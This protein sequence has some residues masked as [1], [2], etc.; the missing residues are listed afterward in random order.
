M[1]LA[2]ETERIYRHSSKSNYYVYNRA[3]DELIALSNK[4]KQIYPA[5][6][7]DG[8]KVAYVQG[9][10]IHVFDIASQ[11]TEQITTDG[12]WNKIINGM[13]DWVYEE[14]LKLTR[15]F[16]WSPDS[17]K[18]AYFKFDEED[19]KMF[20]MDYYGE[21][22]PEAYTFKYPKAGEENAEVTAHI[23]DLATKQ[24]VNMEMDTNKDVYYARMK[25]TPSGDK[26]MLLK[27]NRQQNHVELISGNTSSGKTSLLYAE[28]NP[29]Y[30]AESILDNLHFLKDESGF[31]WTSENDG[32][33]HL[34]YYNM[35][36]QLINQ[37]TTGDYDVTDIYGLDEA[38]NVVY[39]QS[40]ESSPLDRQVY[41]VNLNG[42]GKQ[43]LT[44][45]PGWHSATFTDSYD[46]FI[47][48]FSNTT[49]PTQITVRD[50][51]GKS[52]RSLEDNKE[53]GKQVDALKL[54]KK[55]FFELTAP[56]GHSLNGWMIKPVNFDSSKSYPMMMFV[57]GGPGSQTVRNRWGDSNF[58][59][60]Q[61]LAQKGY[62]VVSVDNRGT[63]ARG[64][65]FKKSTYLQLGKYET[66]D[67]IFAAKELAKRSFIDENRIGIWGWS[68]GGYMSSLALFKGNDIFDAAVAVAPVTHWGYYDT[69]YTE[70]FMRTPQE[71]RN[72]YDDNSPINFVDDL[73]GDYLLV[74]GMGD[75]NVHFQNTVDMISALN[76]AGKH[77]DL[78]IYPNKNHGIYGGNTRQHLFE[79]ITNFLDEK[80]MNRDVDAGNVSN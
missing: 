48:N 29:Y 53:L 26:L 33:H 5:F 27:L 68:Y 64:Q 36:G 65:E 21:L 52:V 75:D 70:R 57:Y 12:E 50:N 67:Q 39:Y 37:V 17:K 13:S 66:E 71:N 41:S 6:S 14:E 77:Y 22:Y 11:S 25:W 73:K 19:V 23:H 16:E 49:T 43:Q 80:L 40:A 30:V 15:A 34:Y 18:I 7:P 10:N 20:S 69:I 51:S 79:K 3:T 60:H 28:K 55:E 72:G 76:T 62:V 24:V 38:N 78:Y 32:F 4:D 9:N 54:P 46:Y 74:H 61:Y 44:K 1:L 35:D 56:Q 31:L 47:H 45:G 59:Y 58:F 42:S 63:G 8:S 2:T